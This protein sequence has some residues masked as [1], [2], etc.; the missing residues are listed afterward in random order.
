MQTHLPD[1]PNGLQALDEFWTLK[2]QS[3][4]RVRDVERVCSWIAINLEGP[5]ASKPQF[6]RDAVAVLCDLA[7]MQDKRL[8]ELGEH[9]IFKSIVERLS[10]SFDPDHVPIYD[11]IFAQI[12]D[13]CRRQP[14]GKDLDRT[15]QRFGIS[16]EQDLLS[17]K[18]RINSTRPLSVSER[19]VVKKAFVLS[20]VTLGADVAVTSVIIHCLFTAFPN[21]EIV[22]VGSSGIRELYRDSE[23]LRVVQVLYERHGSLSDRLRNW[24]DL[25]RVI[26]AERSDVSRSEYVVVDPDSRLTQLGLLPLTEDEDRYFFFESRSYQKTGKGRLGQLAREWCR[27]AFASE[28]DAYPFIRISAEDADLGR[29][30]CNWFRNGRMKGLIAFNFGVGENERKRFSLDFETR[31]VSETLRQG[32]LVILDKGIGKEVDRANRLTSQLMVSG[33]TVLELTSSSA[34]TL[35]CQTS[36]GATETLTWQGGVGLFAALIASSDLYVGY[37]SAFQHIAAALDVPVLDIFAQAG[38]ERFMDRWT[39]YSRAPVQVVTATSDLLSNVT[40]MVSEIL[41]LFPRLIAKT[42]TLGSNPGRV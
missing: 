42:A 13:Y 4:L 37:D 11:R 23:R 29:R 6:I 19:S 20:R 35:A 16:S 1:S 10:D 8:R 22:L 25:V 18:D 41:S 5:N 34:S 3:R 7:S 36:A 14:T 28:L 32:Y 12:I 33:K 21:A 26:D 39:P 27:T 40:H 30:Y 17:R 9:T 24:V 2:A 38:C 31:L 15:L